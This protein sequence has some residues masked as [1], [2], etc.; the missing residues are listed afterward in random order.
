[1]T[2]PSGS[3]VRAVAAVSDRLATTGAT[4]VDMTGAPPQPDRTVVID[5]GRIAWVGPSEHAPV[6]ADVRSVAGDGRWLIPGLWDMH[7]H[8]AD[9]DRDLAA[10]LSMGVTGIRDMGGLNPDN[11]PRGSFS[12]PWSQLRDVRDAIRD[13]RRTG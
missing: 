13:K 9:P 12:V 4:V 11:P 5:R 6:P 2:Q 3:T 8:T 7:V 1:M 10:H